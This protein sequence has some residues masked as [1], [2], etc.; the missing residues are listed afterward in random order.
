[1]GKTSPTTGT[2]KKAQKAEYKA[3]KFFAE[4]SVSEAKQNRASKRSARHDMREIGKGKHGLTGSLGELQD[5]LNRAGK[6]AEKFYAPIQKNAIKQFEQLYPQEIR[7][8]FGAAAGQGSGSSSMNQALSAARVDLQD[9]LASNFAGFKTNLAQS[10]L[11][12]SENNK[13]ANLNARMQAHQSTMG[14]PVSP[15]GGGIQPSYNQPQQSQ[16]SGASS[17]LGGLAQ[18]GSTALTAWW[19]AKAAAAPATGGASLAIPV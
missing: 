19:L 18:G 13:L 1:M 10:M 14:G 16:P 6:D 5:K 4:E 8:Q 7:N 17:A 15:I 11:S 12:Q 3:H 9:R 2:G